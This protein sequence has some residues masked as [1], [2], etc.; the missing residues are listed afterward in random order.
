MTH[1][2]QLNDSEVKVEEVK[3]E[4]KKPN[5]LKRGINASERCCTALKSIFSS[6]GQM[7]IGRKKP[8]WLARATAGFLTIL[9]WLFFTV[10]FTPAL[11]SGACEIAAYKL[12]QVDE[13]AESGETCSEESS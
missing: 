13:V 1:V 2:R 7:L 3:P 12:T 6:I 10:A 4:E 8:G 11:A 5:V 9:G